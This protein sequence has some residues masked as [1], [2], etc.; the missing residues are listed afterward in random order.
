M[1]CNY[2]AHAFH[3]SL[4]CLQRQNQIF[5]AEIH[6][7]HNLKISTCDPLK[8]KMGNTILILSKCIIEKSIRMKKVELLLADL[9]LFFGANRGCALGVGY[10]RAKVK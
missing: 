3:Q 4:H 6:H 5:M 8:Y 2:N 9:K 7:I 10:M 1:K